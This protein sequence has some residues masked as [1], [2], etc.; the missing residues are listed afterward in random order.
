MIDLAYFLAAIVLVVLMY[1]GIDAWA[2]WR[3][4]RMRAWRRG[5]RR[6]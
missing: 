4:G 2:S 3:R 5:R 1:V 6:P